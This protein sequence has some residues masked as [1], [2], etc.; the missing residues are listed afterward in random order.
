MPPSLSSSHLS[1]QVFKR[2]P[3]HISPD[4][5]SSCFSFSD[6]ISRVSRRSSMSHTC[7][8]A[9]GSCTRGHHRPT[10]EEETPWCCAAITPLFMRARRSARAQLSSCSRS[11]E[12]TASTTCLLSLWTST[13]PAAFSYQVWGKKKKKKKDLKLASHEI[14]DVNVCFL[15]ADGYE[16]T[17][18][19]GFIL[20]T[21]SYCAGMLLLSFLSLICLWTFVT[22][23]V[24]LSWLIVSSLDEDECALQSPCSHSCNNIMGGFSCAC[25]SGFT[26]S[27]ETNTCQGEVSW[28]LCE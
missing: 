24:S 18:P 13:S 27:S 22:A 14:L 5:L 15:F 3:K 6:R 17:C 7:R 2:D 21:A 10:R 23:L 20:D 1:L 16:D 11:P 28:S 12:W 4:N 19:K 26:I 9:K 25:P 8:R